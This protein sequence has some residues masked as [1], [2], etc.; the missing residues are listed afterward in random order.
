MCISLSTDIIFY[1]SVAVKNADIFGYPQN[2]RAHYD[3]VI[4]STIASQ[5]TSLASVYSTVY[6]GADQSKL[7]SSASL[8]FVWGIHRGPVNSPHK[9]PVTRKMF[10][11]DDVIIWYVNSTNIYWSVHTQKAIC[12]IRSPGFGAILDR[13]NRHCNNFAFASKP[14]ELTLI[15]GTNEV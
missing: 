15:F 6:S 1:C 13:P 4:M 9:W 3:D 8:A 2:N 11:F 5:I 10:S 12:V 14:F 7:Q